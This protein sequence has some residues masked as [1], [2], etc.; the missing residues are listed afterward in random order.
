MLVRGMS[1]FSRVI[2]ILRMN[3][4]NQTTGSNQ[5][6][7]FFKFNFFD[8]LHEDINMKRIN[9]INKILIS[10]WAMLIVTL[11][12]ANGSDTMGSSN[13]TTINATTLSVSVT[14]TIPVNN[15]TSTLTVTNTGTTNTAYNVRAVL[16]SGWKGVT[17]D[18]N[19]CAT[20]APNNG[21]CTLTFSSI[22][23]YVA[24]GNITIT[25]DNISSPPTTALAFTVTTNN[26]LVWAVSGTTVQVIDTA[27]LVSYEPWG[28]FGITNAQSFTDGMFNTGI[29]YGTHGIGTSA[30]VSCYN[31]S[32][33]EA[34]IGTWYLPAIC[35]MGGARQ[36]ADCSSGLANIDTNLAQ[37][38]FGGFS[39][40]DYWSSTE[41]VAF[42]MNSPANYAW[43]QY[44]MPGGYSVQ[45][46]SAKNL[47]FGVRCARTISY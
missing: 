36:G 31:S 33:G 6:K 15:G 18:S 43:H 39:D 41:S 14:G 7:S 1:Y 27:D 30:A 19:N 4:N 32:N 20:I 9:L 26:Y 12:Y 47:P 13:V 38:G 35:E 10:T 28:R 21:T 3:Q 40:F 29:I 23:P 16:P 11:T 5:H 42:P 44:F 17:Q 8:C 22:T 46:H 25:G 34:S 24:Q 37:L 45:S 2:F